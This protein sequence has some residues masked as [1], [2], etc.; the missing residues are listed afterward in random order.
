MKMSRKKGKLTDNYS[1]EHGV[2]F[3]VS[4]DPK[5]INSEQ[6]NIIRTNIKFSSVDS[7]NKSILVTSSM[8]SEGKSTVALNIAISFASSGLRT[9]L[10]DVDFRRP[11][12]KASFNIYDTLGV[13]N[14]LT[15]SKMNINQIVNKTNIAELYVVSSG[16]IPP[17][18]SELMETKKFEQMLKAFSQNFDIIIYDAAPVLTVPDSLILAPKVDSTIFV[19]RQNISEKKAVRDAIQLLRRAKANISGTILNDVEDT[20][21]GYYGYYGTKK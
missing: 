7:E 11:T 4:F 21:D 10:V 19:I 1:M 12:L 9:L 15:D 18:P 3:E 5:S 16:P 8:M 17:N 6:F 13:T 14:F 2:P 20:N